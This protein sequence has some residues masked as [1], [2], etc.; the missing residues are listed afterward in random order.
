ML[1]Y[2]WCNES[3]IVK[4][5]IHYKDMRDKDCHYDALM[6]GYCIKRGSPT[7]VILAL[8][9]CRFTEKFTVYGPTVS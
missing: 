2:V 3:E 4:N 5:K 6:M 7:Q 9:G 8:K 1:D